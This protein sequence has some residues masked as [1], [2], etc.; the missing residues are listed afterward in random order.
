MNFSEKF[1]EID[2]EDLRNF[3]G[4]ELIKKYQ[5]I[6]GDLATIIFSDFRG[7]IGQYEEKVCSEIIFDIAINFF[8]LVLSNLMIYVTKEHREKI[9]E[10]I[11]KNIELGKKGK[12]EMD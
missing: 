11:R 12:N 6:C 3:H 2:I 8:T 5:E 10:T 7:M 4:E 1:K 9:F